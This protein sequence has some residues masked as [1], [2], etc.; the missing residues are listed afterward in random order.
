VRPVAFAVFFF[1]SLPLVGR[2]FGGLALSNAQLSGHPGTSIVFLVLGGAIGAWCAFYAARMG[3]VEKDDGI[4]VH[5]RLSQVFI[6]WAKIRMIGQGRDLRDT[7]LGEKLNGQDLTAFALL[8]DGQ[9]I[10]LKG[11]SAIRK[12]G[13]SQERLKDAICNLEYSRRSHSVPTG[14]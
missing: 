4:V 14:G 13:K 3:V 9:M 10:P 2:G 5:N 8:N 11:L 1:F 12:N 6:P 7:T